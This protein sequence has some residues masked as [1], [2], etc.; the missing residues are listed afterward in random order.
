MKRKRV[1]LLTVLFLILTFLVVKGLTSGFDEYVYKEIFSIRNNFFDN[2]FKFITISANT[3]PVII[4]GVVL[5]II[6]DNKY[7]IELVFSLLTTLITNQVL[8]HIIVRVRPEHLKLIKQGGYAYPSGHT[9]MAI[10]LYGFLI[11]FINKKIRNPIIKKLLT[12][13]LVLLIIAIGISRVYLGVHYPTDV[14]AGFL[15]A[16]AVLT[17]I[18]NDSRGNTNDKDGSN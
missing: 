14:I 15:I 4:I 11:Y 3:L 9:M 12:V 13:L 16:I 8:K 1:V 17:I 6:F 2:F 18:T 10:A 5:F 7:K